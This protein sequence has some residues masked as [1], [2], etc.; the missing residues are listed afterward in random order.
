M[1]PSVAIV[2]HLFK[3]PE[4][5]C[6]EELNK[7]LFDTFYEKGFDYHAIICTDRKIKADK[8]V[9]PLKF[10]KTN[11]DAAAYYGIKYACESLVITALYLPELLVIFSR[12][13]QTIHFLMKLFC[14]EF[15][16]QI[17][18]TY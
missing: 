2:I 14:L 13:S 8:R 10:K 5:Y 6:L 7:K 16:I 1:T 3:Q 15:L 18:L 4:L 11:E 12:L 17:Y 9:T